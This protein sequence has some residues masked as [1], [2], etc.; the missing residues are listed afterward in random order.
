MLARKRLERRSAVNDTGTQKAFT[1]VRALLRATGRARRSGAPINTANPP[2][3]GKV[4]ARKAASSQGTAIMDRCPACGKSR[5]RNVLEHRPSR[6]AATQFCYCFGR[7]FLRLVGVQT[8]GH[9]GMETSCPS[10]QP[11]HQPACRRIPQ[12]VSVVVLVLQKLAK[13]AAQ[14][15]RR[16]PPTPLCTT[17]LDAGCERPRAAVCL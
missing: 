7:G 10:E 11:G 5:T 9:T 12:R 13:Q 6:A 1:L 14:Q 2:Q 8:S 17:W 16:T 3:P 4:A 15:R